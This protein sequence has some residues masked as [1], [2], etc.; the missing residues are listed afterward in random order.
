MPS[1]AGRATKLLYL[2]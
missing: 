1:A 2:L